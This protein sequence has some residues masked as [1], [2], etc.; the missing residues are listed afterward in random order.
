LPNVLGG[1]VDY[2]VGADALDEVGVFAG[3]D[4]RYVTVIGYFC[5]YLNDQNLFG[6]LTENCEGN[7]P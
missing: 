6:R 4:G 3:A 2:F 1:I 7:L 5:N